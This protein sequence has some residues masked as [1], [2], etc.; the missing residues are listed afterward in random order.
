MLLESFI[1]ISIIFYTTNTNLMMLLY[2]GGIYIITLGSLLFLND[3]DVYVGFLWVID[4]GVGLVFFIFILHFTSFLYQKSYININSRFFTYIVTVISFIVSLLYFLPN[5]TTT[6]LY[7]DLGK[8]W[9]FRITLLDYYKVFNTKGVTELNLLKD[10]YFNLNSFEFYLI[11]FSLLFGLLSSIL[12]YFMIQ[13]I[14]NILN[15]SQIK[16]LNLLEKINSSFFIRTQNFVKQQNTNA[17][18]RVWIK[19]SAN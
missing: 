9:F 3:A 14:F 8:T 16:D 5:Y 2:T 7:S 17:T 6:S 19:S 10:S 12:M 11:N 13:K 1:L 18:V 4:L 15:F